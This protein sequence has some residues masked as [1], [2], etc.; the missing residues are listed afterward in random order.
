MKWTI[1]LIPFFAYCAWLLFFPGSVLRYFEWVSPGRVWPPI[2]HNDRAVPV[3]G[4]MILVLL[5][6]AIFFANR[7][8]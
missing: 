7:R 2:F 6:V 8:P 5:L 4:A 3:S 1:W